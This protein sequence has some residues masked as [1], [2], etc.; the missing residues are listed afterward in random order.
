[1]LI[2]IE[3]ENKFYNLGPDVVPYISGINVLS[4]EDCMLFETIP[5]PVKVLLQQR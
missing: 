4:E 3:S 1:M 2:W 5:D